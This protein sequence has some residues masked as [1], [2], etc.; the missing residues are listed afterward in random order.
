M[1]YVD[2]VI[3]P[4]E[5]VVQRATLHWVLYVSGLFLVVVGLGAAGSAYGMAAPVSDGSAHTLRLGLIEIGLVIVALG[6]VSL[7]KAFVRRWTTEIAVTSKRVIY[8][9]G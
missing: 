2:K 1:S 6:A 4:G 8:K 9:T 3:Q 7:L 5:T